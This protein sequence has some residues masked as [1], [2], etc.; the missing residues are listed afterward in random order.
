MKNGFPIPHEPVPTTP[1]PKLEGVLVIAHEY[2]NP[3]RRYATKS[4][5]P[6]E[7]GEADAA[8]Y[9]QQEEPVERDLPL[10]DLQAL[11]PSE[12]DVSPRF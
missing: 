5:H 1:H 12:P 9:A 7:L 10:A 3:A 6:E 8:F 2:R 4:P 11:W